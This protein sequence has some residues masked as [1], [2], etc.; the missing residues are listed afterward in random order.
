MKTIR[1]A[2]FRAKYGGI[3]DKLIGCFSRGEYSHAEVVFAD[4]RSW[5][6]SFQ[7]GG[8]RFKDISYSHPERWN[9]ITFVISDNVNAKLLEFC[10]ANVGKKYDWLGVLAFIIPV[11]Q[12]HNRLFCSEAIVKA[13]Q[14]VNLLG[15]LR[16]S[17][18]SPSELYNYICWFYSEK[19][20]RDRQKAV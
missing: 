16:A 11:K 7:D 14:H 3:V 20:I 15:G 18:T 4:G 17:K 12:S 6:S 2:F 1:I 8:V 5:S 13:F 9:D 19:N 10:E